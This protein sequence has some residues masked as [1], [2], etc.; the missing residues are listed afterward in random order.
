MEELR[1]AVAVFWFTAVVDVEVVLAGQDCPVGHAI[2]LQRIELDSPGKGLAAKVEVGVGAEV[3][4]EG[5]GKRAKSYRGPALVVIEL[6]VRPE[7]LRHLLDIAA[8]VGIPKD[9]VLVLDG[10]GKGV[11]LVLRK[12][13]K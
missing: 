9:G 4:L 6:D 5:L 7:E 3:L 2:L 12:K 13:W 11:L 8:V 10:G 1:P